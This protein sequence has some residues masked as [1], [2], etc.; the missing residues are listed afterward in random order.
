VT[1]Q[2]HAQAV[3]DRLITFGSPALTAHDGRVPDGAVP[4][5]L[6]VRFTAR[7][8]G[9]RDRP[10]ASDLVMRSLPLEVTARIYAVS[11]NARG[12]RALTQRVMTALLDWEP[13]VPGRSC[14][15]MR[16]LDSWETPPDEQTGVTYAE[17]GDEYRFTSHPA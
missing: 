13:M 9:A 17:L 15:P 14:S 5:Y 1:V 4:P 11:G 7:A 10:D 2:E 12:A 3:L 16:H 6:L 8:L